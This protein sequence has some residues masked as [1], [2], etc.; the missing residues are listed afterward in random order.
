MATPTTIPKPNPKFHVQ[1]HEKEGRMEIVMFD[2]DGK[3]KPAIAR[4]EDHAGAL[5]RAWEQKDESDDSDDIVDNEDGQDSDEAATLARVSAERDQ[6]VKS[7][8][9][10]NKDEAAARAAL[11]SATRSARAAKK[12]GK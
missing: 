10:A 6:L 12:G 1:R 11:K 3:S 2:S 9:K 4:D 5:T 7:L 8:A